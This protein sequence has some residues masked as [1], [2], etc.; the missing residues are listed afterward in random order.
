MVSLNQLYFIALAL[1]FFPT[2][3]LSTSQ[4]P[5]NRCVA[6]SI[7]IPTVFSD[8]FVQ[9]PFVVAETPCKEKPTIEIPPLRTFLPG[10]VFCKLEEVSQ[11]PP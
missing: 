3:S 11:Q 6:F 1:C 2:V 5:L 8:L 4:L 9:M 10:N 7:S